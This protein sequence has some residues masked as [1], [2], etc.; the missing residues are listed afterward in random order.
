MEKINIKLISQEF[1]D[2]YCGGAGVYAYELSK[3]LVRANLPIQIIIPSDCKIGNKKIHK[4][5]FLDCISIPLF[6]LPSF[7]ISMVK[8]VKVDSKTIIHSNSYS[9]FPLI[10][11]GIFLVTIHHPVLFD[12]PNFNFF[13]KL[14]SLPDLIIEKIIT[15]KAKKIIAV[16]SSTKKLLLKLYPNLTEK[17]TVILEGVDTNLFKPTKSRI[18]KKIKNSEE[19]ILIFFPGGSRSKRKGA[20]VALK[21]LKK[22]KKNDIKFTCIISGANREI[23]WEKELSIKINKNKLS[24]NILCVGELD[25]KDLP[26]YYSACDITIFPSLF[27]GFGI[28]ILESMACKI[29]IIASK[30]GEAENIIK[31]DKNGILID[32]GNSTQLYD[33]ILRLSKSRKLR[34][35]IGTLGR[36][37]ILEYYSWNKIAKK[38]IKLYKEVLSEHNQKI[39]EETKNET[40]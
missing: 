21:A 39:K 30:T 15:K 17:T 1:S 36:K 9:G 24:K 40:K 32:I 29:P 5:K 13:Q 38:Y 25:Y 18:S 33:A 23:G 8:K 6:R 31:N 14:V 2:K 26:K 20:E 7:F 11:K 12:F 19:D 22:L 35:R 4:I 3:A 16:S 34:K 37:S 28:P 10:N 27:E